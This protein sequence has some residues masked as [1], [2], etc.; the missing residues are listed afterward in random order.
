MSEPAAA[1]S[2]PNILT[3]ADIDSQLPPD[4]FDK[5]TLISLA[6]TVAILAVAVLIARRVVAPS[7]PASYKAL[8]VWHAFDALIHFLLE[9]SYLYHCFFSFVPLSDAALDL[10]SLYPNTANYLG[11]TDRIYGAQVGGDNPF[12]RL[13]MVYAKADRRWAGADVVCIPLATLC[14]L[15]GSR[16]FH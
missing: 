1:A 7:T 15:C 8:F 3:M 9:G 10:A 14:C 6:S 16:P 2:T 4:L 5:V 13:W 12:A 11:R